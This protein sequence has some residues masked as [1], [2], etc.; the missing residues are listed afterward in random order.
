MNT[1]KNNCSFMVAEIE[2]VSILSDV[3]TSS[4]SPFPGE[5]DEFDTYYW[6]KD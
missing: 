1:N 5:E 6:D 3:I 4:R 2:I